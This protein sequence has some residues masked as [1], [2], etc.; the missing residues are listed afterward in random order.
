M[1][2]LNRIEEIVGALCMGVMVTIAFVNVVARYFFKFSFAFTEEL[3]IYLFVWAT[4]M[5]ASIAFR[6]G[7][8]I[9]VSV[10][11]NRLGLNSRKVLDVLSFLISLL[12]F[13]TLAYYSTFEVLDEMAL[14][15]QTEAIALPVWWFTAA[16]P[17][18]SLLIIFRIIFQAVNRLRIKSI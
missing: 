9:V 10:I 13:G 3:T 14:G 11:Y 8:H 17:V 4:M 6:E 2:I 18:C 7:S 16:M 12:F 1:R 5:G 15:V